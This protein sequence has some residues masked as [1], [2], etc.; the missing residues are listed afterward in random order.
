M[1][2]ISMVSLILVAEQKLLSGLFRIPLFFE[3]YRLCLG[4]LLRTGYLAWGA[5]LQSK[6][7]FGTKKRLWTFLGVSMPIWALFLLPFWLPPT[8]LCLIL[9]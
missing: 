9:L 8:L 3:W 7:P 6:N 4:L 1:S 2:P 5:A